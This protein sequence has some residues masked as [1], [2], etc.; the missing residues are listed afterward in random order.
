LFDLLISF[1]LESHRLETNSHFAPDLLICALSD[2]T[3]HNLTYLASTKI[4]CIYLF[5][6]LGFKVCLC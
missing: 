4:S 1:Q 5:F 6:C 2:I 3:M